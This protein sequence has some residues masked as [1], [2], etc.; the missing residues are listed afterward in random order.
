MHYR[1]TRGSR[2]SLATHAATE[3]SIGPLRNWRVT[4]A[5]HHMR[6]PSRVVIAATQAA[7]R[8]F[9]EAVSGPQ[10]QPMARACSTALMPRCDM[11]KW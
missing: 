10:Q 3:E 8:A 4:Q 11:A 6:R 7:L 9:A 1:A 2:L 5:S